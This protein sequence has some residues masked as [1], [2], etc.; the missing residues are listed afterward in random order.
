MTLTHTY[1]LPPPTPWSG[2]LYNTPHT[3]TDT[4]TPAV[5]LFLLKAMHC[6]TIEC[7]LPQVCVCVF[8]CARER[9]RAS[10]GES[11]RASKEAG[12]SAEPFKCDH[13]YSWAFIQYSINWD[14]DEERRGLSVGS[15]ITGQSWEAAQCVAVTLSQAVWRIGRGEPWEVKR[16]HGAS[17]INL[18]QTQTRSLPW[19]APSAKTG[20]APSA[21]RGRRAA[22]KTRCFIVCV[23]VCKL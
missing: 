11:E 23:F 17:G 13:H 12:P 4:H 15:I 22:C 10:K 6:M 14:K 21:L 16:T 19:G 2:L 5:C 8:V 20:R 7:N 1:H 3:H 18:K 9:E